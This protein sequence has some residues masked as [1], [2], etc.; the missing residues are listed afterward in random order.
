MLTMQC[1]AQSYFKLWQGAEFLKILIIDWTDFCTKRELQ[2]CTTANFISKIHFS[3]NFTTMIY[4]NE[5]VVKIAAFLL[6]NSVNLDE[7]NRK[8]NTNNSHIHIFNWSVNTK[9]GKGHVC[10][11]CWSIE[12]L[13]YIQ[14]C[15]SY[16][17][18]VTSVD[19]VH[20]MCQ[21]KCRKLSVAS[22]PG[23][24]S[25]GSCLLATDGQKEVQGHRRTGKE[26]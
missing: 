6:Y 22:R 3:F 13:K 8:K 17:Q 14:S 2:L 20:W 1:D 7:Y 24:I 16:F 25:A 19:L 12:L 21:T 4:S 18:T 9:N 15:A 26:T 11:L 23:V 10:V 5:N